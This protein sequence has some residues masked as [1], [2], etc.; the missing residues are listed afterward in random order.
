MNLELIKIENVNGINVVSS[1]IIAEQLNKEHS[2]VIRSLEQI[3][4]EPNVASLILPSNYLDK[5]GET[6]KEYLLTKDGFT[7]YMFNIQGYNDF[8]MAYINEFNRMEK[9][10][11]NQVP[12][13]FKEALLLAVKQQEEIEKLEQKIEDDK[14]RVSFAETIEKSS[15]CILVREFAKVLANDDIHIGEKKIY[16]KLREWGYILL[17]STEPTQR[18]VEQGLFKINER[19]FKSVK[20]DI[21]SKTTLITGK[22]Q[23]FLLEK[24]K[25]LSQVKN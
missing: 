11:H 9:A 3:L 25:K 23:M 5:K 13:N 17:N 7:L 6:R 4:T 19:I 10:L 18:A 2:K 1:R 15:E 14:A 20:G 12:T 24:F 8:K 22:G 16:Q 21:L